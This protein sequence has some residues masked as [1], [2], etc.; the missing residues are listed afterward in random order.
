MKKIT[1][2]CVSC[3]LSVAAYSQVSFVTYEAVPINEQSNNSYKQ[4]QAQPLHYQ[5]AAGY[6][7]DSF[8]EDFKRIKI[9]INTSS[10]YGQPQVFLKEIYNLQYNMWSDC[11]NQ[12]SKVNIQFDGEDIANN[13]EWK[14]QIPNI[15]TIYFND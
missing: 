5:I 12:A 1:I 8:T 10:V 9:K 14:A 3:L 4:Q 7:Y 2:V 6:Y 11:N 13:F 15:G